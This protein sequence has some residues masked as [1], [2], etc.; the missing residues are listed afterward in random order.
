VSTMFLRAFGLRRTFISLQLASMSWHR[1]SVL[2]KRPG[3]HAKTTMKAQTPKD[4]I[5]L[6]FGDLIICAGS[7]NA[8][9]I[10]LQTGSLPL[11]RQDEN[12]KKGKIVGMQPIVTNS[13]DLMKEVKWFIQC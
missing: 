5:P 13:M 3:S 2:C 6:P 1:D 9:E 8:V 12:G 4:P 11:G 7:V 10:W